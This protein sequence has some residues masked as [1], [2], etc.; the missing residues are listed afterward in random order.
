MVKLE[1]MKTFETS[2]FIKHKKTENVV[3]GVSLG[4]SA[5]LGR[6]SWGVR[7]IRLVFKRCD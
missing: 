3:I 7:D 5:N 1:A 4:T 2:T 6:T